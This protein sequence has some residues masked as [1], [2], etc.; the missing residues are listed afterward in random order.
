MFDQQKDT[1][2]KLIADILTRYRALLQLS[3]IQAAGD[4]AND[5][6]EAMAVVGMSMK[7]EFDGLVCFTKNSGTSEQ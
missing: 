6:P 4:R 3:T 1:H 7:M 2:E 5:K